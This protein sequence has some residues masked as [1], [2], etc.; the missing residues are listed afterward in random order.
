M[1]SGTFFPE[2]WIETKWI[3]TTWSFGKEES[4]PHVRSHIR[5]PRVTHACTG[6]QK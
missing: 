6:Y 1:P 3:S 4:V 2:I 5:I